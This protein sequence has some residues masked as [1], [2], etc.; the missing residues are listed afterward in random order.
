MGRSVNPK[1]Y[2]SAQSCARPATSVDQEERPDD[3]PQPVVP[4]DPTMS[5]SHPAVE[6]DDSAQGLGDYP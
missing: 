5:G 3:Q 1:S 2:P 6:V 4:A